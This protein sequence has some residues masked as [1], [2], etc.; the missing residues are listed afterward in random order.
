M[1]GYPGEQFLHGMGNNEYV[2]RTWHLPE[3]M[4]PTN[5]QTRQMVRAIQRRDPTKPALWYLS[6]THPHPP[7]TPLPFYWNMYRDV[8]VATPSVGDWAE[9][10][11]SVPLALRQRRSQGELMSDY[12]ACGAAR[13]Y[14]LSTHIDHQLRVVIGALRE[15]KLLDETILL[16]T[17]DHGDMLGKHGLWAKKL[18]YEES[19]RVPMIL[20]G[21]ADGDIECDGVDNRLVGWQD[22]MPTLLQLAGL[23]I[24][25]SVRGLSML[26]DARRDMLYGELGRGV[27]AT[28]M[29]HMGRYKLIYYPA[30]NQVQLFDLE[31]DPE[32][33][34]D[35]AGRAEAAGLRAEMEAR[36][37]DQLSGEDREWVVAGRLVGLPLSPVCAMEIR[38][39]RRRGEY[40]GR[41]KNT[42]FGL[43]LSS[44][45]GRSH[46]L[47]VIGRRG[48][49]SAAPGPVGVE[50]PRGLSVRS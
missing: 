11:D 3:A 17:S 31:E 14:A 38:G 30:G 48:R 45:R 29:V 41:S 18:Y 28:R 33:L 50:A 46:L 39:C 34:V 25:D 42:D 49:I 35:I 36:L 47:N 12:S 10:P 37:A 43:S 40:T 13:F 23:P 24:P 27:Q 1:C 8:P 16:F 19:A 15:Q 7:L 21:A 32:E 6:Y 5:W 26:S 44:G 22:I 2:N 20:V 9:D 4:H